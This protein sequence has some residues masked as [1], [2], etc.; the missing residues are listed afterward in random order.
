MFPWALDRAYLNESQLPG[1]R[2]AGN[3]LAITLEGPCWR[4]SSLHKAGNVLAV[5][6]EGP[7]WKKSSYTKQGGGGKM[8]LSW[9][10]YIVSAKNLSHS[11]SHSHIKQVA[12]C[13][14]TV[15]HILC[16]KIVLLCQSAHWEGWGYRTCT[17]TLSL[18]ELPP[19]LSAVCHFVSWN[20]PLLCYSSVKGENASK[21]PLE[22]SP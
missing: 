15:Q 2:W 16:L 12:T 5:T 22:F 9:L 1:Y 8:I 11:Y 19:L 13:D 3:V 7:C 10:Q 14:Q 4:R 18:G 6:L 17:F 20:G 21:S